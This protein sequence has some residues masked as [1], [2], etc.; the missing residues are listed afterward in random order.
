MGLQKVAF[1]FVV[2]RGGK[3]AKS[4]LCSK[5][6]KTP[7]VSKLGVCLSN[8]NIHFQTEQSAVNYIKHRLLDSLNRP[9][10]QQFERLVV[11]KGTT[12]IGQC[13]GT[14]TSA[15]D[16]SKINGMAERLTKDIPRDIEIWHS[17]PDLFGSGRT[18]PLSGP[19]LGDIGTF[20]R[21]K[22]KKIIAM[23]SKGELNTIEATKDLDLD[24][25]KKFDTDFDDYVASSMLPD[26][27][28][29]R[30][31]E[32]DRMSSEYYKNG[33]K[34]P[35]NLKKEKSEI[36]RLLCKISKEIEKTE[37]IALIEHRFYKTADQYGMKY[38]TDFSNL[39]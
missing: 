29:Q 20:F 18:T 1:N 16:L 9:T 30:F 37:K 24:K 2:E 25:Y 32:L 26:G 8:G 12:I 33:K 21:I 23:N 6:V 17:H 13:D 39:P 10:E 14:R 35:E 7:D 11:K 15:S 19:G 31:K 38:Y 27:M 4:W 5:P 36:F 28:W 22:A 34:F 3:L